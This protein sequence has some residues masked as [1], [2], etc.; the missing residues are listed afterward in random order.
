[1]AFAQDF[2]GVLAGV[3]EDAAGVELAGAVEDDDSPELDPVPEDAGAGDEPFS[4]ELLLA[5]GLGLE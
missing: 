1:M 5:A 3:E 4:D 2:A